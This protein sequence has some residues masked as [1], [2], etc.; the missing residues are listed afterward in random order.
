MGA[1]PD[2]NRAGRQPLRIVGGAV[3]LAALL[4]G[5]R[6]FVGDVYT[7]RSSSMEPA[8]R[9]GQRV[10]V[11]YSTPRSL[12][13][14]APVVF[15]DPEGNAVIKRVAGLPG[16]SLRIV[17]GD[18]LVDGRRLRR[19]PEEGPWIELFD[20]RRHDPRDVLSLELSP[21][22]P[23][24]V[25]GS[26][27]PRLRLAARQV[28]AGSD[29]GMAFWH[30][31]IKDGWV[32]PDGQQVFGLQQVNDLALTLEV[33]PLGEVPE[34]AVVRL[35]LVEGLDT[36]ELELG[37]ERARLLRRPGLDGPEDVLAELPFTLQSGR[38]R[39]VRFANR[40]D[41]LSVSLDGEPLVTHDYLATRPYPGVLPPGRHTVGPQVA[42]GATG[43]EAG[44]RLLR[45]ERDLYYMSMGD[46]ATASEVQLSADEVFLL[47]DNSAESADSRFYGPV[48]TRSLVGVPL[49]VR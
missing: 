48:S 23:W 4:F 38:A 29:A 24:T 33:E 37:L 2:A 21:D 25:D 30:K 36:F 49:G 19:A 35:R 44:F 28:P 31:S 10:A 22:G 40:D 26:A 1:V 6:A 3:L 43:L 7:V 8:V 34:G 5:L 18:L 12:E 46:F 13:R 14:F 32:A 39:T 16:E 41:R 17:D 47:G 27:P 15:R 11:V 9:P 20:G 42:F 45:V